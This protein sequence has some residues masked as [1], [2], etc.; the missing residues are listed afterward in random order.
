[1]R[2]KRR[3]QITNH[4][5]QLCFHVQLIKKS[6]CLSFKL[7]LAQEEF[8]GEQQ[9]W[10]WL[11]GHPMDRK[12]VSRVSIWLARNVVVLNDLF[13]VLFWNIFFPPAFNQLITIRPSIGLPPKLLASCFISHPI[14]ISKV[15][16]KE[17]QKK[18]FEV[19]HIESWLNN[20]I[21]C[22]STLL[23]T[24]RC[25]HRRPSYLKIWFFFSCFLFF[26]FRGKPENWN[27]TDEQQKVA[28]WQ[29]TISFERTLNFEQRILKLASNQQQKKSFALHS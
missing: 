6:V 16:L 9:T 24:L 4:I 17:L 8:L 20:M 5:C 11:T 27:S 18:T 26:V 7:R 1:M 23:R 19:A 29:L 28:R 21:K 22:T 14:S 12:I 25:F 15:R 13:I 10:A 2:V 3:R